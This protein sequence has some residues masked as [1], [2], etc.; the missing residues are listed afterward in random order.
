MTYAVGGVYDELS[1]ELVESVE[2]RVWVFELR[3]HRVWFVTVDD[4]VCETV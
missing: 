4:Q 1:K 2:G 3:Y